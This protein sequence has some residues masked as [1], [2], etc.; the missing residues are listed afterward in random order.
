VADVDMN[1]VCTGRG[2]FIEIQGTAEREPFS[3]EQM[4]EMLLLAEKGVN[5]LFGTQRVA[6]A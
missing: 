4:D 6:L 5:E 3:R 2:Q 1:I